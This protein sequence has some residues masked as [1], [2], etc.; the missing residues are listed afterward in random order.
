MVE[1]D[2]EIKE[3]NVGHVLGATMFWIKV[4]SQC[5]VDN[6]TTVRHLGAAL[7]DKCRSYLLTSK[8]TYITT[9]SDSKRCREI[10]CSEL[11]P[12][13]VQSCNNAF[14]LQRTSVMAIF[15][16]SLEV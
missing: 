15:S 9:I 8:S 14:L 16:V 13:I 11:K 12:V 6:V 7:I 4:R 1:N 5:V 2:M 3:Y 10:F